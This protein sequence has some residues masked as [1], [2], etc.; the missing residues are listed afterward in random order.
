MASGHSNK[1]VGQAGEYLVAGELARRGLISTTFTGNVPHYDIIAS[2]EEGK[3]VSVQVKTSA[4]QSWQF[5]VSRFC[6]ITFN[7]PIQIVGPR[8]SCPVIR[9]VCVLVELRGQGQDRFFV[10]TWEQL[11]DV[12]VEHHSRWLAERNSIRPKNPRS[13]HAAITT[14]QIADFENHWDLIEVNLM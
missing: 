3:H 6:D 4:G 8:K 9:L 1:L 14:D 11:R 7:D 10:L 13:A 5:N 2:D 12:I